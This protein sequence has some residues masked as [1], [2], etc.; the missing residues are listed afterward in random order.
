MAL[1]RA[2]AKNSADRFATPTASATALR[3]EHPPRVTR[4]SRR[5]HV[6]L[7]GVLALT[8]AGVTWRAV[9]TD[10]NP[11]L[12]PDVIAVLVVKILAPELAEPRVGRACAR[13]YAW[14]GL[15]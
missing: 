8:L 12:D 10:A 6:A 14:K 13:C 15:P 5:A 3:T 2:L 1:K 7:V 11:G 4:L 9:A